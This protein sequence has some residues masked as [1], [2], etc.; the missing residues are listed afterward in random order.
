MKSKGF[1]PALLLLVLLLGGARLLYGRLSAEAAPEQLAL[2]SGETQKE[3]LPQGGDVISSPAEDAESGEEEEE[4]APAPDFMAED[5]EGK[6]VKLSDF[7]GKPVVLNFWASWCGPCKREMPE[8]DEA[9][10]EF[11]EEVQFLMVNLTDGAREDRRSASAFIEKEGYRF[12]IYFDTA[13]D[14]AASYA[15]YSIPSTYFIDADGFV[16]GQVKGA[17]SGETLREGIGM[18]RE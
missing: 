3:A 4:A 6:V 2:S 7:K 17:L 1:L 10:A 12:P 5:A 16:R 8:F 11:G 9:Y 18:I 14:G 13:G 15:V